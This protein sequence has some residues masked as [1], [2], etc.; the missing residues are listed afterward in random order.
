MLK[1]VLFVVLSL[2]LLYVSRFS[3]RFP[4]PHGFYRFLAWE[5]ILA[6]ILVNSD[7]WFDEPLSLHQII[8]WVLLSASLFLVVHGARL[9]RLAGRPDGQRKDQSLMPLEKTTVL[10]TVGAYKHIRHPLYSSLLFL[11]WG[12]FFKAPSWTGGLLAAAATVFLIATAKADE[13]ECVRYF[14]T[15]YEAYMARTKRFIPLLF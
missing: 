9:L 10:V 4:L 1:L 6:L 11:G 14:G 13:V 12:V 3:L 5:S 8:S 7:P 15:P 2:G